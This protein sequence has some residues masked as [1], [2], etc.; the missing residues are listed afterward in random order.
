MEARCRSIALAV[1]GVA[2]MSGCADLI[3][4]DDWDTASSSTSTASTSAGGG[5]GGVGGAGG[6]GG[7]GDPTCADG[8]HNGLETDVDCGGDSCWPCAEGLACGNDAD[9]ATGTCDALVCG[10]KPAVPPCA[11]VDPANPSCGDCTKNGLETGIDCG[12]DACPPCDTGEAC[13]VDGDCVTGNC[14]GGQCGPAKPPGCSP[15]DADNPSC[16]DCTTNGLESDTDCGGDA[17][18]P[19]AVGHLCDV[20]AD[21]ATGNCVGGL[22]GAAV[23]P[24]CS[25]LDPFNATCADCTKNGLETGVDCGGDSCAPCPSGGGCTNDADCAS[26][27]CSGGTCQ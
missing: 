8:V 15:L 14:S 27:A 6:A 10:P 1:L 19:C 25:P 24:V 17:C 18:P 16:G 7:F 11:A 22:C 4:I 9:C 20:D 23:P 13:V 12:G 3:G 21:C 2:A 5:A 26:A